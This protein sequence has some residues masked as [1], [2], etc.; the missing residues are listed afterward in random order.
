[1]D[2]AAM[3]VALNVFKE[4]KVHHSSIEKVDAVGETAQRLLVAAGIKLDLR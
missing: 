4:L 2:A 3:N 1:M